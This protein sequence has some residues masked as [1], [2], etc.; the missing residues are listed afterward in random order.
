MSSVILNNSEKH[1]AKKLLVLTII[2][3]NIFSI[4]S[5]VKPQ[6]DLI[7]RNL[8]FSSKSVYYI[9][10]FPKNN[11]TGTGDMME[12]S[13]Y[14]ALCKI[15]S[16]DSGC[17]VGNIDS[18]SCGDGALCLVYIDYEAARVIA[19]AVIVPIFV[20]LFVTLLILIFIMRNKY[21]FWKSFLLAV[22]CLFVIT[23][24]CVLYYARNRAKDS[25]I[26]NLIKK[27]K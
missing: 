17:C 25:E 23:I 3:T 10:P 7:I 1:F 26:K 6:T 22:L 14:D 12:D 20:I 15:L 13:A 21:S 11:I 2:L 4:S 8:Q 16:C 27:Q 9:K 24:P 5:S 18:I 19:P